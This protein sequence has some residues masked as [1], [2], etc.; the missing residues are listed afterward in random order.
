LVH[1]RAANRA[2]PVG[3]DDMEDLEAAA[4]CQGD[5]RALDLPEYGRLATRS[6]RRNRLHMA[7]VF[8]AERQAIQQILDGDQAGAL[9]VR[10][11]AGPDAFQKLERSGEEVT[12][13]TMLD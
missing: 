6:Q 2:A 4:A 1:P 5:V 13:C 9:Q 8:V 12:Q 10:R 11:L 3:E 7:A